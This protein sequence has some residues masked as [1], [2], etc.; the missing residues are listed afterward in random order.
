M[1]IDIDAKIRI[2]MNLLIT[3]S[4]AQKRSIVKISSINSA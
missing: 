1:D 4:R 2:E 3:A